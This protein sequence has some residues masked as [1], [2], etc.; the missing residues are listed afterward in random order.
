MKMCACFVQLENICS[1]MPINAHAHHALC[2][3]LLNVSLIKILLFSFLV[4]RNKKLKVC[5]G[6]F[7]MFV[8]SGVRGFFCITISV[9]KH[10]VL[11]NCLP[12]QIFD[13]LFQKTLELENSALKFHTNGKYLFCNNRKDCNWFCFQFFFVIW[14]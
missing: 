5:L 10:T 4:K 7:S 13:F 8:Y 12:K 11:I 1:K 14:H 2:Y 6:Y 3:S 9:R